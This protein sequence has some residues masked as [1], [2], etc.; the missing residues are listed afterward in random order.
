MSLYVMRMM[1]KKKINLLDGDIKILDEIPDEPRAISELG[2]SSGGL[3]RPAGGQREDIAEMDDADIADE[4][5]TIASDISRQK[6]VGEIAEE[7]GMNPAM[8]QKRID[9]PKYYTMV[10]RALRNALDAGRL[11][12][13]SNI[14]EEGIRNPGN[15]Q[16]SRVLAPLFGFTTDKSVS[17]SLQA[18]L[19]A[20]KEEIMPRSPDDKMAYIANIL[21]EMGFTP[22]QYA[23]AW[24]EVYG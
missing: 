24:R 15:A 11:V 1:M 10:N 20:E 19:D 3:A 12:W 6:T 4:Y 17:V 18:R 16:L 5:L 9:N 22:E 21:V 13:L 7:M 14:I 8:L 23:E 2:H